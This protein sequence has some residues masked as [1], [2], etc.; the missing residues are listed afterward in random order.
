MVTG[1]GCMTPI[2]HDPETFWAS[3][4][5]GTSGVGP[6]TA[7]DASAYSTRIAAEVKDFDPATELGVKEARRSDRFVQMAVAAAKRAVEHAKLDLSQEDPTR[8]GVW[9]GSGMGGLGTI[10]EGYRQL[11]EKGPNRIS[12]FFI[13]MIICNMA[14]GQISIALGVKGPNSCPVSACASAGH[15]LGDA[16]RIIQRGEA[17]LMVAGGT[18][19]AITPLG[20]AGFCAMK[21]LST[22]NEEPTKASRPF[23]KNRDG[24]VMGEGSGLVI[25]EELEHAKRRPATI[26]G[27]FIGYAMTA[28]AYH[29]TAPDPEGRGA[30]ECMTLALKDAAM[31]PKDVSYINAHGTSTQ[32]NDKIETAAIKKV[33]GEHAYKIPISSTKSMTGHMLGAGGAI[34][35]IACAMTLRDQ[36]IHPTINYETPDSECDLDYVPNEPRK[37]KVA[38]ILSNSLGFGG[39]NVSLILRKYEG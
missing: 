7:F 16:L 15:A 2:G 1:L 35:F 25:L 3:L 24:F 21:A 10:E 39:H 28:D 11:Q 12:P 29:M 8:I 37:A 9:V 36:M 26:Y 38:V 34:E 13:P 19:C 5:R 23:D 27:E 20:L 30:S 14:P 32:L 33:F 17:D 31:A 4:L 6:I 18:E 22:R